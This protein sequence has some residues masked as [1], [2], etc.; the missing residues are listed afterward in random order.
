MHSKVI[1]RQVRLW[2]I[3]GGGDR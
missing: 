2:T 1:R 3:F